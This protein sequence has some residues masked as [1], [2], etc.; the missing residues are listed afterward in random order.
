MTSHNYGYV[1]HDK[2]SSKQA[3]K[4]QEAP[5]LQKQADERANVVEMT[6]D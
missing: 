6:K 3:K 1:K 4:E 5:T 2:W